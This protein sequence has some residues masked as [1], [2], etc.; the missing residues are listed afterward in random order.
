MQVS[1]VFFIVD[2]FDNYS[3]FFTVFTSFKFLHHDFD[4]KIKECLVDK[5]CYKYS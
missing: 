5:P 1:C 2:I 4:Q 3:N